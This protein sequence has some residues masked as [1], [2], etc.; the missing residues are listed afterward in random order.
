MDIS[1][2]IYEIGR[3]VCDLI[4]A[5]PQTHTHTNSVGYKLRW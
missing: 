2:G 1:S 4:F 5:C 3:P